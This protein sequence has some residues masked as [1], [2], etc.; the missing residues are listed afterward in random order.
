MD[1]I[2]TGAHGFFQNENE[3]LGKEPYRKYDQVRVLWDPKTATPGRNDTE[4]CS[5]R[6]SNIN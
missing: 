4:L 1:K 2:G 5:Q 6:I 3:G